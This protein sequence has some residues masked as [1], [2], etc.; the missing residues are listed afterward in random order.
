M[1][2]IRIKDLARRKKLLSD[3]MLDK[4]LDPFSMT[5]PLDDGKN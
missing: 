4:L 3:D 2:N 5:S 1:R